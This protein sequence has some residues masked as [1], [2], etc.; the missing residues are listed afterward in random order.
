MELTAPSL[1][2]QN[3]GSAGNQA[4]SAAAGGIPELRFAAPDQTGLTEIK[5]SH[6]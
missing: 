2:A 6:E 3:A 4:P 5:D 1:A